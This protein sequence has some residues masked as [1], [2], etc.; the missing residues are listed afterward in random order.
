MAPGAAKAMA[1]IKAEKMEN[2]MLIFVI[3]NVVC[4]AVQIYGKICEA[5]GESPRCGGHTSHIDSISSAVNNDNGLWVCFGAPS[6]R[7][8]LVTVSSFC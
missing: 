7:V 2:F 5:S 4:F 8:S 3:I 1:A 6:R